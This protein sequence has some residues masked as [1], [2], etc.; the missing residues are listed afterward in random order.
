MKDSKRVKVIMTANSSFYLFNFR[1]TTIERFINEGVD[2]ICLSPADKYSEKLKD[3]GVRFIPIKFKS[4]SLNPLDLIILFIQFLKI[5]IV[6][7]PD[8][9]FNF[10]IKNNIA[11]A[12][13]GIFSGATVINN[14]SGLGTAFINN[15]LSTSLIK[16]LYKISQIFAHTVFCQN[17]DDFN[18]LVTNK[19][20][21]KNKL[22]LIPGWVNINYYHPSKRMLDNEFIN[23]TYLGRL[24][25]D[26]GLI[27]L[28]DAFKNFKDLNIRLTICGSYDDGNPRSIPAQLIDDCKEIP[29]ISF[30]DHED[31]VIDVLAKT[32]F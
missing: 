22:K 6:N 11:G 24:L 20:I 30:I 10:T 28:I 23:F 25:I 15:N 17:K 3:L 9:I 16:I 8:F 32:N 13:A 26:K 31:N 2:V 1:A 21:N 27:E 14:I 18:F 4:H 12:L 5:F 19:I 7:K 29:N